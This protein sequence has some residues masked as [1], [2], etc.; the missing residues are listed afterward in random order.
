MKLLRLLTFFAVLFTFVSCQKEISWDL[1][2]T[3]GGG[4]GGG[5][6]GGGGTGGSNGDLFVK[7]IAVTAGTTD[8]NIIT[9]SWDANK[10]LIQYKST[11]KTNGFDVSGLYNITRAADS[12]I[13]KIYA[14]PFA[15]FAG[16][17]VTIDSTVYYVN[18]VGATSKLKHVIATTYT[19]VLN[20]NDSI[21]Y[22][23]NAN[24]K[25]STKDTYR[26][27]IVTGNLDLQA[28]ET[29]TYDASG[30]VLTT[31]N[32]IADPVTG[33]LA[34]A[35]TT[36]M[37]YTA[38]KPPVTMGE[39]AYIILAPENTSVNNYTTKIQSGNSGGGSVTGT[40]TG[41]VTVQ[42]KNSFGRPTKGSI[43]TIPVPPGYV[44]NFTYYYQ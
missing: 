1:G 20:F 23:Y 19:T 15:L 14:E 17:P 39:E 21:V 2:T 44:I 33:V 37:T 29:Y 27:N 6:T 43:S 36:T 18:Y 7:G 3:G 8:T 24:N 35:G 26:E 16:M 30:N 32:S 42:Q 40:I 22:T 5:G 34:P 9:L 12:R 25:I 31:N 11:G 10:K 41:T 38:D 13:I 4:T 28:K